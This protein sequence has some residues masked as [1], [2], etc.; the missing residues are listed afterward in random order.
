MDE[1]S[2]LSLESAELHTSQEQPI[3][4]TPSEVPVPRN[5]MRNG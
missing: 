5:V 2:L 1:R 3:T 4:G